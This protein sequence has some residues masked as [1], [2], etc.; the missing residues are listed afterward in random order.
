MRRR[1][2]TTLLIVVLVVALLAVLAYLRGKAPPEAARILPESDGIVYLNLKPLRAATHYDQHPVQHDAAYQ[3]FIDGTGFVFERDLN[4]AAFALHR[5]SD[6]LGPNGAVAFSEVFVGRFDGKRL[7]RY[8]ET[9]SAARELYAG[10]TVYSI[11]SEG[12]TVRVAILGYDM[13]GA[14]NMPTPEQI[15][16]MIDRYR[17]AALPFSGSSVLA[18]Y[19]GQ[20]PA[21]SL[22]W[23]IGKI[24]L[25]LWSD[26]GPTIFGMRIPISVDTAFVA[27][28][29]WLGVLK[30]RVEEIAPNRDAAAATASTARALAGLFATAESALPASPGNAGIR[31]LLKSLDVQQ[32][33]DRVVLTATLPGGLLDSLVTPASTMAAPGKRRRTR[34]ASLGPRTSGSASARSAASPG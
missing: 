26:G 2:R 25:P 24:T 11:P 30:L 13:V 5:M 27:S 8:L 7:T 28:L 18:Q 31:E 17:T 10:H 16:A 15:H 20:V 1:T 29:R 33:G 12:R 9:N 23:G 3:Q 6:P 19:Y 32:K 22:A 21:L 34:D 14:S 4:E